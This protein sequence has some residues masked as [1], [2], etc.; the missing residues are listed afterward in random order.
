MKSLIKLKQ[1]VIVEGKYDKI[2]LSNILDA[3]IIQTDGFRI[4][5][6]KETADLIK[7]LAQRC[8]IVILTDSDKAGQMIRKYVE[9]IAA[10][11]EIISVYLPPVKGKEK[12]KTSPSSDGVLGVEGTDDQ[13][14][15]SA[16]N[17]AGVTG[18]SQ[19]K[20]DRE[21]TK[22]DLY[23]LGLSGTE[24]SA[25][26]RGAFCSF[27]DLPVLPANSLL[28]VL[29]SLYDYDKFLRE[30]EKWKQG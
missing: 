10:G 21:I 17:R 5:K 13:I 12:R 28:C 16:L 11:G 25:E 30:V 9:K 18:K 1:A 24:N 20:K 26:N 3:T 19:E 14:I 6:N 7:T 8:G 4:F 29:N 15:I 2:R 23:L 27:L 22:T